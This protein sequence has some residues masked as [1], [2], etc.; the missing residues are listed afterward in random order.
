MDGACFLELDSPENKN[1]SSPASTFVRAPR[2]IQSCS[3]CSFSCQEVEGWGSLRSAQVRYERSS[4]C[5]KGSR[6]TSTML[7]KSS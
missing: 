7:G 5:L 4:Q 1:S 3:G 2:A 6:G